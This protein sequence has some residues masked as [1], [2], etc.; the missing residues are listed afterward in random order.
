MKLDI[1]EAGLARPLREGPSQDAYFVSPVV[2]SN[3][4]LRTGKNIEIIAVIYYFFTC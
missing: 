1:L 4:I 2:S 3:P